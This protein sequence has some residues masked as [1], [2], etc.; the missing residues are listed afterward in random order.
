MIHDWRLEEDMTRLDRIRKH[1]VCHNC[2]AWKKTGSKAG[3]QS[4]GCPNTKGTRVKGGGITDDK[5]D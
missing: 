2:G 1:W 5:G 4:F 3:L